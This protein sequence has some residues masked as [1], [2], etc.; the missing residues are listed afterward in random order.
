[1]NSDSN[2]LLLAFKHRKVLNILDFQNKT[3]V[4][5]PSFVNLNQK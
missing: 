1:M 2:K 3:P 5:D 4:K